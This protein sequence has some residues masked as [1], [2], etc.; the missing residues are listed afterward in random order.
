MDLE[1]NSTL[2]VCTR[3]RKADLQKCLQ[4]VALSDRV[5]DQILI[6]DSSD[7]ENKIYLDKIPLNLQ[8]NSQ[9]IYSNPGLTSQ[10]NLGLKNLRINS[11]IVHFIDDDVVVS[12][13]YFSALES[14]LIKGGLVGV[15]GNQTNV[16]NP[17][18]RAD[19]R[20]KYG[21]VLPSGKA[22]GVYEQSTPQEVRWLPGC[23]MSFLVS[24][25]LNVSFNEQ[26]TGYAIGEDV[27]FTYRLSLSGSL[28][29][30]PS[31]TLVHNMS[32][33]NR[34]QYRTLHGIEILNRY[35]IVKTRTGVLRLRAFWFEYL[36]GM[37]LL[38]R[39][40]VLKRNGAGLLLSHLNSLI[41]ILKFEI[42][43]WLK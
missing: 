21:E 22:F 19:R 32:D 11:E 23:S 3:N 20:I 35:K 4:S 30:V 33:V 31:A 6:V 16:K 1:L 40:L 26:L 5:P 29:Y 9:I 27:E 14:E 24:A 42:M 34:I 28:K 38:S 13:G 18:N 15:T 25:I 7:K 36:T 39:K 43:Q 8:S 10:R 37:F 41:L 2:I 17:F 12:R